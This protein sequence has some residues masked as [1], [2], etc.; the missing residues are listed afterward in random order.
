MA[1]KTHKGVILAKVAHNPHLNKLISIYKLHTYVHYY[2]LLS[3]NIIYT[4]LIH[5]TL[6]GDQLYAF[7]IQY[8]CTF[9]ACKYFGN[10]V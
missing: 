10:K 3:R 6:R 7:R 1:C 4:N 8:Y 2:I 9:T 5:T